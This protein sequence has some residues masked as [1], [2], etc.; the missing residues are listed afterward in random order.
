[1]LDS[2]GFPSLIQ[3]F[4][5]KKQCPDAGRC[6]DDGRRCTDGFH[7]ELKIHSILPT[8]LM[9]IGRVS[10]DLI[11]L[12]K[13]TYLKTA[14]WGMSGAWSAMRLGSTIQALLSHTAHLLSV[15]SGTFLNTRL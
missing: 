12:L 1:M 5:G 11:M 7:E 9:R 15:L 10:L 8:N 14:G 13:G 2:L 3:L 4:A 6:D